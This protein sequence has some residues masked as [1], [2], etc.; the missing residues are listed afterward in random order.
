MR[1][2]RQREKL[3][4]QTYPVPFLKYHT[5]AYLTA[6]ARMRANRKPKGF[7]GDRRNCYYAEMFYVL[8]ELARRK[9]YPNYQFKETVEKKD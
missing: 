5:T 1:R 2:R 9:I 4:R 6:F 8:Q 7:F 3:P